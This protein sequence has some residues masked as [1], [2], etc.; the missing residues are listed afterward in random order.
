MCTTLRF[1]TK[2]TDHLRKHH[3]GQE[4]QPVTST[5]E[6]L[7]VYG[8]SNSTTILL[9]NGS[10][11]ADNLKLCSPWR[12]TA[13]WWTS[14]LQALIPPQKQSWRAYTVSLQFCK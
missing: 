11:E 14:K 3:L 4:K 1:N 2:V 8:M 5:R 10:Q 13:E 12:L 9:C 6:V 7:V